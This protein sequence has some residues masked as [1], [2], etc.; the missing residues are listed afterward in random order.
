[1]IW[2][3]TFLLLGSLNSTVKYSLLTPITSEEEKITV[4]H[5]TTTTIF[6][7]HTSNFQKGGFTHG[8]TH[9][10]QSVN[11]VWKVCAVSL[12]W[13]PG[14]GSCSQPPP[15]GRA[16]VAP[17]VGPAKGRIED[18]IIVWSGPNPSNK[19][20]TPVLHQY[21]QWGEFQ[22]V[23]DDSLESRCAPGKNESWQIG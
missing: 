5:F 18:L 3:N 15:V 17:E 14:S 21:R 1:M 8:A 13:S 20:L 11:C 23:Q 7:L 2:W 9:Q 6:N 22:L 12:T 19:C 10:D 16:I 4:Y